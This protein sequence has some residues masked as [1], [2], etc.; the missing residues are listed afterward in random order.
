[1]RSLGIVEPRVMKNLQH[2]NTLYTIVI[3]LCCDNF[4]VPCLSGH[5]TKS[6]L[7]N[8]GPRAKRSK[9]ERSI[10]IEVASQVVLLLLLCFIGVIGALL[11]VLVCGQEGVVLFTVDMFGSTVVIGKSVCFFS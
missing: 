6:M 5:E 1:M 9:L 8:S 7:N 10:N 4:V 11:G 2:N 3:F